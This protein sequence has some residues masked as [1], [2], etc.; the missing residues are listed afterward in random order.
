[1]KISPKKNPQLVTSF[2]ILPTFTPHGDFVWDASG[3]GD[4]SGP[5]VW[6]YDAIIE[7]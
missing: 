1:M 7:F 2:Q 6:N 5:P 3:H 4:G